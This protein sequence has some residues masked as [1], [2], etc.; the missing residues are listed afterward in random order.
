MADECGRILELACLCS[1][2]FAIHQIE[3]D[4]ADIKLPLLP[5]FACDSHDDC[6]SRKA[7]TC[8][9]SV[10]AVVEMRKGVKI[11]FL[12]SGGS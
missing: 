1:W 10:G 2:P 7:R 11:F 8:F 3:V 9:G 4:F 6:A 5:W 12:D